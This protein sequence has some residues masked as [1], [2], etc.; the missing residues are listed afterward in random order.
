MRLIQRFEKWE[1]EHKIIAFVAIMM[2]T[3]LVTRMLIFIHDPDPILFHFELHHFDYGLLLLFVSYLL[4]IFDNPDSPVYFAMA[5]VAFGLIIDE[6][7]FIRGNIGFL[8]KSETS[9]YSATFFS[10]VMI[11]MIVIFTIVLI[12]HFNKRRK[13]NDISDR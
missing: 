11:T 1:L 13:R 5:A 3:I 4:T 6:L 10:V 12:N 9:A 2:T 7:S 8:P